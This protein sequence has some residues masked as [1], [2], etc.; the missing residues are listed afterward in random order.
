M[1]VSPVTRS[2]ASTGTES[3]APTT[4]AKLVSCPC[5]LGP[6]PITTLTLPSGVIVISVRSRGAPIE[7]ST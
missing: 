6:V 1:S 7:L 3:T 2:M 4:W 5:P